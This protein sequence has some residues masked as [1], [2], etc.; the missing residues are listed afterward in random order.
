MS[1]RPA[2]AVE[3]HRV[4][5]RLLDETFAGSVSAS[6]MAELKAGQH[7]RRLLLLKA[8]REL[9]PDSGDAW[10]VLV[11]AD[12]RAP[13]VVRRVLTYPA[14]GAWLVRVIRKSRGVIVDEIPL[15]DEMAY[16]GSVAAAAAIRGGVPVSVDVP[17]RNGRVNLPTIGQFETGGVGRVR[18]R[19]NDDGM[20]LAGRPAVVTDSLRRH[21]SEVGGAEV[22][23][24]IDDLDPYRAFGT[25]ERPARLDQAEYER[26]CR[27]LDEA[28]AILVRRHAG[29]AAE[30]AQVG[31]VIVPVS[32][33]RG[34]V[35]STSSSAFGAIVL[36]EPESVAS[37]AETLVHELQHS[38]LNAVLDLVRL[39]DGANPLCYAPWR[40]DPRPLPGLLHGIYAF[41]S[42]VE[43]WRT[44]RHDD[45]GDRR[46]DFKFLY[47]RE[48]VRATV[49][50]VAAMP[51]LTEYGARL[52]AAVRSRLALC[53]NEVV[54]DE[55]AQTVAL[56]L[57]EHRLSWRLRH[58]SPP[59]GHVE[60]LTRRWLAD[61][62]APSRHD[63][64][65]APDNRPERTS[66]LPRLLR[67]KA[68]DP[69]RFASMTTDPGERALASGRH[70]EAAEAFASRIASDPDDDAAWT[71]LLVAVHRG[72]GRV[73]AEAV[74]ATYRGLPTAPDPIALASWFT[75]G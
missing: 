26:W 38:K 24:T 49:H 53:D 34:L 3:G 63:S 6:V 65:L 25:V 66:T 54:P 55:L 46:A 23:W 4:P 17:V 16:L 47:H 39:E 27:Q 41:M 70:D 14:V 9:L 1:R 51:E 22:G 29:Y 18:L 42:V 36:S 62:A 7:S 2:G 30:L 69:D 58:L 61:G 44:Q 74:S 19:H 64:L 68:L 59:D 35:A 52:V 31:P 37:L 33:S 21:R 60:D 12:R 43:F 11:D 67:A 71:G 50:A 40:Q 10:Q 15:A 75:L 57:A 73:P 8:I 72:D 32:R 56:L 45:P 28:W 20:W 48:Q 5:L 13:E